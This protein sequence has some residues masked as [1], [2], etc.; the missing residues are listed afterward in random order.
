M[1]G[2]DI[3]CEARMGPGPV[4]VH[5]YQVIGAIT[6]GANLLVHGGVPVGA[7]EEQCPALGDGVTLGARAV[8]I[9]GTVG[10]PRAG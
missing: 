4:L 6:A 5:S 8:I 9:A 3:S 1:T 2:V 7:V 10:V